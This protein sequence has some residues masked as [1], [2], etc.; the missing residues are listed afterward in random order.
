MKRNTFFAVEQVEIEA[1]RSA[2]E[3]LMPDEMLYEHTDRT[4]TVRE[5][6][7]IYGVP[8]EIAHLS[9]VESH[10]LQDRVHFYR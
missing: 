8:E 3:L 7:T 4:M 9:M 6:A 1:N 5:L 2:V 10:G